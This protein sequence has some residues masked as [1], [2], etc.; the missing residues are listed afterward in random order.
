MRF[1]VDV[2]AGA[3]LG[4]KAVQLSNDV[5]PITSFHGLAHAGLSQITHFDKKMPVT[6]LDSKSGTPAIRDLDGAGDGAG[7]DRQ[8]TWLHI[9]PVE[10]ILYFE[11]GQTW[12]N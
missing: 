1:N 4:H 5:D 2:M 6:V 7:H 10:V 8:A 12:M 9:S 3:P 11:S